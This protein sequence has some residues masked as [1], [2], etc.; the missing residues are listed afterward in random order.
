MKQKILYMGENTVHPLDEMDKNL[1]IVSTNSTLSMLIEPELHQQI[2][3]KSTGLAARSPS[4][5]PS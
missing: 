5:N 2:S 4:P 1:S 3:T